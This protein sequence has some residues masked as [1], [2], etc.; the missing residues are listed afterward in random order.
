[1]VRI[2]EMAS[3][4]AKT[5]SWCQA[6][7]PNQGTSVYLYPATLEAT[8]FLHFLFGCQLQ[9]SSWWSY[10]AIFGAVDISGAGY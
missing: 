1:M 2:R 5:V 9:D 7:V 10:L 3:P 8:C 6:S 4:K